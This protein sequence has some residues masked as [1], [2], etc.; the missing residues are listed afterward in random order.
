MG[1]TTMLRICAMKEKHR[2]VLIKAKAGIEKT[3]K[4]DFYYES[5]QVVTLSKWPKVN[6]H[7][8]VILCLVNLTKCMWALTENQILSHVKDTEL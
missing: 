6:R 2:A 1:L 3:N 4:P 7:A 5:M 8:T